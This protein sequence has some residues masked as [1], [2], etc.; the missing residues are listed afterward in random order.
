MTVNV[1]LA[2][3]HGVRKNFD[4]RGN[5]CKFVEQIGQLKLPAILARG[6]ASFVFVADAKKQYSQ[7]V[8]QIEAGKGRKLTAEQ[9]KSYLTAAGGVLFDADGRCAS[10]SLGNRPVPATKTLF[11]GDRIG[12][13]ASPLEA[14]HFAD[15][16]VQS[17]R[18]HRASLRR[19]RKR[20][21]PACGSPRV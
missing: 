16:P 3:A 14:N 8:A 13:N 19:A 4:V 1:D 9:T 11:D 12:V 7:P 21:V 18:R 20:V 17:T 6:F 10:I 5:C 2:L 15:P